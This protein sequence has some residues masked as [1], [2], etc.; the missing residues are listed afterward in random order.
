ML[1][2][3]LKGKLSFRE[4]ER[5]ETWGKHFTKQPHPLAGSLHR[6]QRESLWVPRIR[7]SP[8][9]LVTTGTRSHAPPA[10]AAERALNLESALVLNLAWLIT[11]SWV[12]ESLWTLFLQSDRLEHLWV[13]GWHTFSCPHPIPARLAKMR[14]GESRWK[15][16]CRRS[17]VT[18]IPP[19]T[20]ALTLLM[21]FLGQFS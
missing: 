13:E 14:E 16:R 1:S 2:R 4:Q 21:T 19:F 6:L 9:T 12:T 10:D 17:F 15:T 3:M 11:N 8:G 7:G 20:P 5:E 18:L